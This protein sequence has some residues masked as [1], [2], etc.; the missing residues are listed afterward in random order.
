MKQSFDL[1]R[2]DDGDDGDDGVVAGDQSDQMARFFVQYLAI[3]NNENLPNRI[4]MA[5]G[6]V[7]NFIKF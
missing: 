7:L 4:K 5:K 6:M 2:E 1:A 3:Y